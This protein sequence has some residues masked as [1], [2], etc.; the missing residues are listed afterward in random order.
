M[1]MDFTSL[2]DNNVIPLSNYK[3][4]QYSGTAFIGNP[5]QEITFM[6][7]TGSSEAWTYGKEH[8]S[9][10]T[11][12]LSLAGCPQFKATY[13]ES[14]SSELEV[15]EDRMIL[16]YAKG[17]VSGLISSDKFCFEK[18]TGCLDDPLKFLLV[19]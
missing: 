6:F 15:T 14:K 8:C 1:K 5:S 9:T 2:I 10:S 7:D 16:S 3:N 13:Q 11:W 17:K 18:D 19:D 12:S 4:L